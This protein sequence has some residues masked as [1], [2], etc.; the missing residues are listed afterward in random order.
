MKYLFYNI[1]RNLVKIKSNDTPAANAMFILTI[2]QYINIQTVFS[3][4][5]FA[6]MN[7]TQ[8][9]YLPILIGL[10]LFGINYFLLIK[11]ISQLKEKYKH[12][13]DRQKFMGNIILGTYLLSSCLLLYIVNHQLP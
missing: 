11:N 6:G 1:F 9:L 13:N 4:L 3:S 7:F 5:H 8:P 2:F 10:G 12:E